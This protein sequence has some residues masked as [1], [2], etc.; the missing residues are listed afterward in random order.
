MRH[1]KEILILAFIAIFSIIIYSC[2]KPDKS[3][4]SQF[5]SMN[6]RTSSDINFKSFNIPFPVGTVFNLT[7]DE[8]QFDL[9][10]PFYI[11]GIDAEGNFHRSIAGGG[12][13]V[14]CTCTKG[15]GCDPIKSGNDYGCLMKDGCSSCDKSTSSISGLNVDLIEF[16]IINP[17]FNISVDE[18]SQLNGHF[19]LPRNFIESNEVSDLL[20]ELN[21]NMSQTSTTEKKVAFLNAYGYIVPLEIPVDMDNTSISFRSIG[22]DGTGVTCSCNIAGKS[23]PKESKFGVVWCNSDN[24]T[25]CTMN[26]IISN[27]NGEV[28]NLTVSNGLIIVQ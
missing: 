23:C 6:L 10:E 15:S 28:R 24:C 13:S 12:G 21:T 4:N 5:P 26:G 1:Y 20:S 19:L 25:S 3:E 2:S 14:T 9:P 22:G 16:V 17:E 7:V 11:L 8:L 18:F 27:D